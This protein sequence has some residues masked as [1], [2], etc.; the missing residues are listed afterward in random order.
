MIPGSLLRSIPA[1]GTFLGSVRAMTGSCEMQIV[2]NRFSKV[3]RTQRFLNLS[4][5]TGEV[6]F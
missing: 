3:E 1:R 2:K 5:S 4:F 6:W